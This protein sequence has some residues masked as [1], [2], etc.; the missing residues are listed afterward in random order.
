MSR[1]E[2]KRFA[3]SSFSL[4]VCVAAYFWN[5]ILDHE[6]TECLLGIP[7]IL[8]KY[9]LPQHDDEKP[10][11]AII[12]LFAEEGKTP[13]MCASCLLSLAAY[14]Q[15]VKL[16]PE[17]VKDSIAVDTFDKIDDLAFLSD[18]VHQGAPSEYC[19]TGRIMPRR[20]RSKGSQSYR[21]SQSG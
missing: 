9:L 15:W 6:C 19:F 21:V 10:R 14:F 20:S 11:S 1:K 5:L 13:Q 17:S 18:H 4:F 3:I 7:E 16:I 12:Q 2:V 8:K